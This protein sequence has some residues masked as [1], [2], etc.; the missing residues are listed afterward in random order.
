MY[1]EGIRD[2]NFLVLNTDKPALD[3]SPVDRKIQLG[4]P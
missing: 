2:D 4:L 3:A 1:K